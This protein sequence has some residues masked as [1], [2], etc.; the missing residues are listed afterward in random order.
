MALRRLVEAV[1][2]FLYNFDVQTGL[3]GSIDNLGG[4]RFFMHRF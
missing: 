1:S 4:V 2:I 3:A